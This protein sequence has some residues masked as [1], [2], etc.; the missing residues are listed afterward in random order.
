MMAD[1]LSNFGVPQDEHPHIIENIFQVVDAAV[2]PDYPIVVSIWDTTFRSRS[3]D[4]DE[5]CR[6][7]FVPAAELSIQGLQQVTLDSS[8]FREFEATKSSCA[9][10]LEDFA[11]QGIDQLVVVT[12]LPCSH[13]YHG[14]CIVKW[15][16]I[17][18][19]CPICRYPMPIE[20]VGDPSSNPLPQSRQ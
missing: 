19:L 16:E 14:D 6:P 3:S 13:Y 2:F 15:L 1:C 9:I 4:E 10:G 17:C 12:S 11:E 7:N 8:K 18:H 5:V 20:Q